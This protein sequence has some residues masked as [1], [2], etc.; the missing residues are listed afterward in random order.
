MGGDGDERKPVAGGEAI[1]A[2]ARRWK[3]VKPS[4]ASGGTTKSSKPRAPDTCVH[5]PWPWPKPVTA[6]RVAWRLLEGASHRVPPQGHGPKDIGQDR[7]QPKQPTQVAAA[8][9]DGLSAVAHG[10]QARTS[11]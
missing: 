10:R 6:A 4:K 5:A 1:E 11:Q 3:S 9:R 8:G 2:T 7:Q